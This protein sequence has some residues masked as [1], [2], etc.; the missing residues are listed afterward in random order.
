MPIMDGFETMEWL[1][2][3]HPDL[4]VIILTMHETDLTMTRLV[5]LGVRAI[6][7]KNI[8]EK[9]LRKAIFRVIE[10]GY[11]YNNTASRNLLVGIYKEETK[12]GDLKL[13]L[14]EKEWT[15]LK[16]VSTEMTYK[17]IG[18]QMNLS[19]R[20][21]DKIRNGLFE[22]LSAQSR[23]VLAMQAVHNGIEPAA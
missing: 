21:V 14:T 6:L 3:S 2:K 11:Y 9:E 20:S 5:R 8:C 10:E 13:L 22:K 1:Q 12:K 18:E 19:M 4:P 17:K 15:F 23:V 7:S 16:F